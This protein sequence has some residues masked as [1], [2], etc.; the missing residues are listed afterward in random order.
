MKLT[1]YRPAFF[2]GFDTEVVEDWDG[3]P[4]SVPWVAS[5]ARDP[6]FHR[7]SVSKPN[8]MAE[9]DGGK[10]WWV[11]GIID[12]GTPELPT[13]DSEAAL[14]HMRARRET[15]DAER[16]KAA[17]PKT[18]VSALNASLKGAYGRWITPLGEDV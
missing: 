2:S 13:W 3:D 15:E 10:T 8:L 4:L 1:Q 7:F 18:D 6:K 17:G 11:V 14:V 5:W 12:G 16:T 9:L